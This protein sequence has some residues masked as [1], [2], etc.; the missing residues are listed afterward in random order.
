MARN[1][2]LAVAKKLKCIRYK[3]GFCLVC[4]MD[5]TKRPWLAHFHHRDPSD[6]SLGIMAAL[7]S[8]Y[9]LFVVKNELDKCELLCGHCHAEKHFDVSSF[10]ELQSKIE[11]CADELTFDSYFVEAAEVQSVV[12]LA[13][14]GK[15]IKE[16]SAVT[17]LSLPTVR[18]HVPPLKFGNDLKRKITDSDLILEVARGL[19]LRDIAE[20]YKMGYK[21]VWKRW[22]K[23]NEP[24]RSGIAC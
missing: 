11:K 20:K 24:E 18:K 9:G 15:T 16:I 10:A 3:G 5:L 17:G 1:F 6:K 21:T 23:I 8:S 4:G 19:S 22:R 13:R 12:E 14:Q 7:G 2:V